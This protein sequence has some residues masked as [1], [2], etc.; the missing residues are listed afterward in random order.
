VD[1]YLPTGVRMPVRDGALITL[2]HLSTHRSGLPRLPDGML[3]ALF[4]D[5]PYKDY[6]PEKLFKYL[7][8][9]RLHEKP[10]T[11]YDYSN[12]GTGLL[13]C[14]LARKANKSY[15]Q[16]LKE[17]VLDP[18]QL[19]DTH[20]ELKDAFK[21]RFVPGH[22]E[23]LKPTVN[24]HFSDALAGAGALRSTVDDQLKFLQ[25][26]LD[27]QS[28]SNPHLQRALLRCQKPIS[29]AGPG[30]QIGLGWHILSETEKKEAI[31]WHNGGTGGYRSF[32][33]F[34]P[35]HQL[36][37]VLLTNSAK[38]DP[39]TPGFEILHRIAPKKPT[40]K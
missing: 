2:E 19:S 40:Q 34:I 31:V 30:M 6:S 8:K 24:W 12:L 5:D 35:K 9:T 39:D 16:L 11:K 10:G 38:A 26:H 14:C 15:E 20:I 4:S 1:Y 3:F 33:G 28:I 29:H 21:S 7:P 36:G 25:A 23:S 13:G 22:N 18:L 27:P 17:R 32:V 37:I